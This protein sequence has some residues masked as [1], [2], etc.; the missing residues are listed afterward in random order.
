MLKF[1]IKN[2][3]FNEIKYKNLLKFVFEK[4]PLFFIK[5]IN[6]KK[7]ENKNIGK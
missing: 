5:K 1:F 7:K 6:I 2:T 4:I 3:F